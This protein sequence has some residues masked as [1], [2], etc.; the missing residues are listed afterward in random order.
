[1]T[2]TDT[3]NADSEYTHADRV[4]D[5]RERLIFGEKVLKDEKDDESGESMAHFA[6]DS[7]PYFDYEGHVTPET[8]GQLLRE[9]Y[10]NADDRQNNSPTAIDFL[11]LGARLEREGTTVEYSGYVIPPYREDARVSI[12]GMDVIDPT[13]EQRIE[14]TE[15]FGMAVDRQLLDYGAEPEILRVRYD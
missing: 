1:M 5:G 10:V 6:S 2:T 8:L 15:M 14:L 4:D 9:G 3:P 13:P 7:H 11:Q 12:T